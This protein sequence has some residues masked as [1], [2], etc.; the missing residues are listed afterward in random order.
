M[1]D[2]QNKRAARNGTTE[3]RAKARAIP[4]AQPS[5]L[6]LSTHQAR[7]LDFGRAVGFLYGRTVRGEFQ[8][9]RVG[10]TKIKAC[11]AGPAS[12]PRQTRPLI[13]LPTRS[14]RTASC[15]VSCIPAVQGIA[16]TQSHLS[17]PRTLP[18]HGGVS[19]VP[20]IVRT[21]MKKFLCACLVSAMAIPAAADSACADRYEVIFGVR[22]VGSPVWLAPKQSFNVTFPA[23]MQAYVENLSV[24]ASV[25]RV[26]ADDVLIEFSFLSATEGMSA[27]LVNLKLKPADPKPFAVTTTDQNGV[28]WAFSARSLCVDV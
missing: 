25:R 19:D 27:A 18:R 8:T 1:A 10:E 26:S 28:E 22:P 15:S 9:F 12:L 5:R 2:Y 6:R 21:E 13:E 16:A 20:S 4:A 24:Q 17:T 11:F 7:A 23:S 14:I 3:S